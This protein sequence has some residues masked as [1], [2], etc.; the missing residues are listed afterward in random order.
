MNLIEEDIGNLSEETKPE[1]SNKENRESDGWR[2][3]KQD[4]AKSNKEQKRLK[5]WKIKSAVQKLWANMHVWN[6]NLFV[7]FG[8]K[9]FASRTRIAGMI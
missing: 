5:N 9:A 2:K 1:E 3:T 6:T 7:N 4:K 8:L